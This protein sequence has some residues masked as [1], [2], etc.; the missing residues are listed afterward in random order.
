MANQ[1]TKK[2]QCEQER[3]EIIWNIINSL[4]AA[5]LVFLGALSNGE[6]TWGGIAAAIIAGGIV[7]LTKFRDYWGKEEKEYQSKIF[8]FL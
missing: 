7:A 4:L 2:K 1:Y 5:G 6:L 8:R 3:K